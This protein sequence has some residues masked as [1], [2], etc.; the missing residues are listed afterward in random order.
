MGV[1]YTLED[2]EKVRINVI[3]KNCH[4]DNFEL[5]I[6]NMNNIGRIN[7]LLDY[8]KTINSKTMI[9]LLKRKLNRE[10]LDFDNIK[11]NE[12]EE[13]YISAGLTDNAIGFIFDV[14]EKL[15]QRKRE[16]WGIDCFSRLL[17]YVNMF[18]FY[19]AFKCQR[20]GT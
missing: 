2:T 10:F 18:I 12:L 17:N 16:E 7:R 14:D 1:L 20:Y 9:L 15:V 11:P 5:K 8:A 3:E 13:L 19:N 6:K 4:F